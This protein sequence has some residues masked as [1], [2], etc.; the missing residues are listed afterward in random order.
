MNDSLTIY[1]QLF[2][3]IENSRR[4]YIETKINIWN[5]WLLSSISFE[6]VPLKVL[7][8]WWRR[9]WYCIE[10]FIGLFKSLHR[11]QAAQIS[12]KFILIAHQHEIVVVALKFYLTAPT[13]GVFLN[14]RLLSF[15]MYMIVL[16]FSRNV[17]EHM[18]SQFFLHFCRKLF[19]STKFY[20]SVISSSRV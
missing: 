1:F 20:F 16:S 7:K 19:R 13:A 18:I 10:H 15:S 3:W 17:N 8:L 6:L 11:F 5:V 4:S 9:Y 14:H 2:Q 12:L